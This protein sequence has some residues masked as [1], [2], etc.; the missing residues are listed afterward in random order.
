MKRILAARCLTA[1]VLLTS[2]L[3]TLSGAEVAGVG[4]VKGDVFN[5]T[6]NQKVINNLEVVLYRYLQNEASE[7]GRTRT[8]E[9]GT[10]VFQEIHIDEDNLYYVST[11][12]K[13]V[14]YFSQMLKFKQKNEIQLDLT[15]FEPTVK[16]N[17][18]RIK[19]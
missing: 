14:D 8:Y 3:A 17:D 13:N 2:Q 7:I 15:V 9:N 10:F 6:L 12:Y 11:R 18:L 16:D 1:F 4:V 5:K 19:I